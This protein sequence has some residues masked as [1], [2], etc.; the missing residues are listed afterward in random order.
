[1]EKSKTLGKLSR[2]HG[3]EKNGNKQNTKHVSILQVFQ[4]SN[5]VNY[6]IHVSGSSILNFIYIYII[7][8]DKYF[9]IIII[10]KLI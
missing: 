3:R 5:F 7:Y 1:M 10:I 8:F 6:R 4:N 9:I 2:L